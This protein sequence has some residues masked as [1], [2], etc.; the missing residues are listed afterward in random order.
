MLHKIEE[1]GRLKWGLNYY[2]SE[3]KLTALSVKFHRRLMLFG[4]G[5]S[6]GKLFLDLTLDHKAYRENDMDS[7]WVCR[8]C[9]EYASFEAR[10]YCKGKQFNWSWAKDAW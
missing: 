6:W 5:R 2:I 8:R 3:G 7:G 10:S 4:L 9:G 1:G